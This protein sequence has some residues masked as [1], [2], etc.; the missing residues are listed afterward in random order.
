MTI[1]RKSWNNVKHSLKFRTTFSNFWTSQKK[2]SEA[3]WKKYY[4]P[5]LNEMEFSEKKAVIQ[6]KMQTIWVKCL[7]ETYTNQNYTR[8]LLVLSTVLCKEPFLVSILSFFFTFASIFSLLR[9]AW[10]WFF[11]L[12]DSPDFREC[13]RCAKHISPMIFRW[14]R[15]L[16]NKSFGKKAV[17]VRIFD[18]LKIWWKTLLLEG[19]LR[20]LQYFHLYVSHDPDVFSHGLFWV[21][22][23]F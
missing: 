16:W 15:V 13:L 5:V 7:F 10:P 1:S 11:F 2:T 14:D 23:M 21:R 3:F 4:G 6:W 17:K 19:F 9:V 20:L 12:T 22:G 18:I 8:F